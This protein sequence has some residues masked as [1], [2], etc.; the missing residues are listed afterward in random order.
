MNQNLTRE[1]GGQ[2]N[3]APKLPPGCP[4][5]VSPWTDP[6]GKASSVL[7]ALGRP[8]LEKEATCRP[9]P[10]GLRRTSGGPEWTLAFLL[11]TW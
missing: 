9:G 2:G 10:S 4:A 5:A 11:N 6:A 8:L 3:M 1:P 7:M